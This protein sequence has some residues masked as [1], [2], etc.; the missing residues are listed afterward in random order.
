MTSQLRSPSPVSARPASLLW[1]TRRTERNRPNFWNTSARSSGSFCSVEVWTTA[2]FFPG[3]MVFASLPKALPRF[4][5]STASL[6]ESH[7]MISKWARG[8]GRDFA[9]GRLRF[10]HLAGFRRDCGIYVYDLSKW[11]RHGE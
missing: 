8:F 3:N 1:P 11:A 6:R 4:S 7:S 10:P 5:P 9:G 2:M